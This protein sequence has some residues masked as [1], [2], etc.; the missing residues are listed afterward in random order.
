[1]QTLAN[2]AEEDKRIK[3]RILKKI[4]EVVKTGSPAAVNRG[5]KLID[6]LEK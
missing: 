6:Q 5:K 4:N 3:T 2:L 1:M